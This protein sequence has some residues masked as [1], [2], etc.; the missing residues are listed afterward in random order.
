MLPEC[1][2]INL[3]GERPRLSQQQGEEE[4]QQASPDSTPRDER[5]RSRLPPLALI[6][7]SCASQVLVGVCVLRDNHDKTRRTWTSLVLNSS[8]LESS[9]NLKI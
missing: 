7:A 3:A 5:S 6:S 8:C 1:I 4:D 9:E 2:N